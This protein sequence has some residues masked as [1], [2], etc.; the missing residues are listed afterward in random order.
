LARASFVAAFVIP[1]AF[2]AP[3]VAALDHL[4]PRSSTPGIQVA[5]IALNTRVIDLAL[6]EMRSA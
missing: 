4:Q 3:G 5:K 1:N 6:E 2:H